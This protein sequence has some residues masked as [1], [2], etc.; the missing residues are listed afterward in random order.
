MSYEIKKPLKIFLKDNLSEF[1]VKNYAVLGDGRNKIGSSINAVRVITSSAEEQKALMPYVIGIS[2]SSPDWNKRIT[3]YWNGIS[4]FVPS[5]GLELEVGYVYD[6][7]NSDCKKYIDTLKGVDGK[8]KEFKTDEALAEY[9]EANIPENE[10]WKY[11]RPINTADYMLWRYCLNYR[12]VAN[13]STVANKSP[14]IRFYIFDETTVKQQKDKQFKDRLAAGSLY[15]KI[16]ENIDKVVEYIYYCDRGHEIQLM[17]KNGK[18]QV[19][20]NIWQSNPNALLEASKD[21]QRKDKAFIKEC[22]VKGILRKLPHTS[23]IVDSEDNK[24]IGGSIEDAIAFL[25]SETNKMV[26]NSIE[27][28]LR[29]LSVK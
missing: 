23:I 10:K 11:G 7:A 3:D 18:V 29:G 14:K 19:L 15:Y 16:V 21:T 13:D 8:L 27:G 5:K 20:E 1:G 12:D 22:I 25:N 28:R 9:V 24:E 4:V 2:A 26:R 17:D 6:L